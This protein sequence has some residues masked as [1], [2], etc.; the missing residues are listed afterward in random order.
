MP[1]FPRLKVVDG[2]H[3]VTL[4]GNDRQPIFLDDMDY[5]RYL[6]E[7]DQCGRDWSCNLIAY[8]L[9]PNHVHLVMQDRQAQLSKLMQILNARYTRYFNRRYQR[10]GH[11]YQGRF[12]AKL[13]ARDEYLL[14]VTRYVHLNP[15]RAGLV[16]RPEEYPWSSYRLYTSIQEHGI[17]AVCSDLVLSLMGGDPIEQ[18]LRY[19]DFV[20]SLPPEQW[21]SWEQRLQRL[22]LVSDTFPASKG[23]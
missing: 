6:E 7:L 18:A 12:H 2:I 5:R 19:R 11:L 17:P 20:A 3:H 13:V 16:K 10:V 15:V 21:P 23:V 9:M 8:A 4:R 22:K 1:R 14:E